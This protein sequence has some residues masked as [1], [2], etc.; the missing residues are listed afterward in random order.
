MRKNIILKSYTYDF[1]LFLDKQSHSNL[2][3]SLIFMCRSFPS[4]PYRNGISKEMKF[5]ED[6]TFLLKMLHYTQQKCSLIL[7]NYWFNYDCFS[8]TIAFQL[9]LINKSCMIHCKNILCEIIIADN[10]E[11]HCN[12]F[13]RLWIC[14]VRKHTYDS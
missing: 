11:I 1:L 7:I 14:S 4:F 12:S 8:I 13:P 5:K 6:H 3:Y 10:F 2:N 9:R